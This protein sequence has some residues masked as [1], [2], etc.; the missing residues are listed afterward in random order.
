MAKATVVALRAPL[1][2]CSAFG[3]TAYPAL[4]WLMTREVAWAVVVAKAAT[5]VATASVWMEFFIVLVGLSSSQASSIGVFP[6]LGKMN[7]DGT[8]FK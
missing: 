7:P 6:A 1:C 5:R 8:Y 4:P 3:A 2:C